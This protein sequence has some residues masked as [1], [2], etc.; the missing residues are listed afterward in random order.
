MTGLIGE[1]IILGLNRTLFLHAPHAEVEDLFSRLD[2]IAPALAV[3]GIL[4][5]AAGMVERVQSVKHQ[6]LLHDVNLKRAALIGAVQGICLPF[7]G[8]SRSGS[9]ISIAILMGVPKSRAETFSFA[10]AILLTPPVVV[11]EIVRLVRSERVHATGDLAEAALPSLIGAACAFLAG[12]LALKWL[13]RWLESG[14][15]HLF[16]IYCLVAAG[17]VALL[18]QAGY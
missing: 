17:L 10:L 7:R 12:L 6:P 3:A 2:L 13:S 4:I 18:H 15:W 8:F 5:F 9:T 16:G 11:H 1:A 14:R